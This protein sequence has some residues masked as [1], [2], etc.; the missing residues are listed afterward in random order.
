MLSNT[1]YFKQPHILSIN[2]LKAYIFFVQLSDGQ[3]F[4]YHWFKPY[5]YWCKRFCEPFQG[6]DTAV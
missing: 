6:L 4:R 2:M 1:Q 5:I 3:N